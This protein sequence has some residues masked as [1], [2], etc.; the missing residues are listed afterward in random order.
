LN[1]RIQFV[2]FDSILYYFLSPAFS[3]LSAFLR[4]PAKAG[5]SFLASTL[6]GAC[7]NDVHI[8]GAC[9]PSFNEQVKML[10][11]LKIE[12]LQSPV[13]SEPKAYCL[14]ERLDDTS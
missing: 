11:T 14:L 4:L 2:D 5:R 10:V 3:L 12:Q 6:Y 8:Q 1:D 9:C 13:Y 7:L